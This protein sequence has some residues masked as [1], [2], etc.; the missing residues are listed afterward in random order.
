MSF[1]LFFARTWIVFVAALTAYVNYFAIKVAQR[2][3]LDWR[4]GVR[5]GKGFD[6]STNVWIAI[7]FALFVTLVCAAIMDVGQALILVSESSTQ[8]AWLFAAMVAPAL[9]YKGWTKASAIKAAG[10]V[11][12]KGGDG[13]G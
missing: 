1:E 3:Y 7:T 2:Y 10:K 9:G 11:E 12:G 8:L 6:L 5:A 13:D 4:A